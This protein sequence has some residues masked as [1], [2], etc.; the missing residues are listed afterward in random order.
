MEESKK[1]DHLKELSQR[2]QLAEQQI[3]KLEAE[4][5]DEQKKKEDLV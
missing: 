4:L 1:K 2:Q 5:A 3:A